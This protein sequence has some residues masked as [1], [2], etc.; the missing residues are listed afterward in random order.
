MATEDFFSSALRHF[1]DSSTLYALGRLDE[2]AYLAG[3]V[4]ECGLKK[5]LEVHG[6]ADVR[7]RRYGHDLRGMTAQALALAAILAPGS[8]RYR[9]DEIAALVPAMSY[10][11]PELR[12]WTTGEVGSTNARSMLDAA[13]GVMRVVLVALVLD[14]NESSLR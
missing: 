3:Y 11:R 9:I 4:I 1:E 2:A 7:V 13:T 5:L 12:Y 10:W 6:G 14:G 8:A